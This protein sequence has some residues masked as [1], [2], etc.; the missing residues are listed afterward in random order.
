[1]TQCRSPAL[2]RWSNRSR[3]PGRRSLLPGLDL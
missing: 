1:V 2:M 3:L